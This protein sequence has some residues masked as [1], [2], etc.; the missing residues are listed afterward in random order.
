MTAYRLP[1]RVVRGSVEQQLGDLRSYLEGFVKN[2]NNGYRGTRAKPSIT[3]QHTLLFNSQAAPAAQTATYRMQQIVPNGY[4]I[5]GIRL[6]YCNWNYQGSPPVETDNANAITIKAAIDISNVIYPVFFNGSRSIVIDPGGFVL[7]DPLGID[8]PTG[9]V[10]AVRTFVDA[11]AGGVYPISNSPTTSSSR[12]EGVTQ[13]ADLTDVGDAAV[14]AVNGSVFYGPSAVLALTGYTRELS[15]LNL[16]DSTIRG[17]T[18]NQDVNL[19]YGA[20]GRFCGIKT[21]YANFGVDGERAITMATLERRRRR[22]AMMAAC[23]PTHVLV[24]LGIND[25]GASVSDTDLRT[26][27][28]TIGNAIAALGVPPIICCM[29][30]HTTSTDGWTSVAGQTQ[31]GST[32]RVSNNNWRRGIPAPYVAVFDITTFFESS[33][34]SGL[35]TP[36]MTTDGLHPGA[37]GITTF[38]TVPPFNDPATFFNN[39][40]QP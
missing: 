13:S 35:W 28:T 3:A 31:T 20:Y 6:L 16:G 22:F 34:D 29:T 5:Q 8:M 10:Y 15:I 25:L 7:S 2:V 4:G 1:S 32:G 30:P 27:M 23:N 21:G 33:S 38:V 24:Q 36:G 18:S 39:I 26:Y 11:G 14:T 12:G 40:N 19:S 9:T 17:A 37:N